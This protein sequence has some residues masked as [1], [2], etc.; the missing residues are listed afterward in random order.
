MFNLV[1]KVAARSLNPN[2]DS[3]NRQ[4]YAN[5]ASMLHL[6]QA[7]VLITL[8]HFD[9]EIGKGS[10]RDSTRM[11]TILIIKFSNCADFLMPGD[12]YEQDK[13]MNSEEHYQR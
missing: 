12:D 1:I 2:R 5:T 6:M 8:P 3:R 11:R 9:E 10:K 7:V 13:I 4:R